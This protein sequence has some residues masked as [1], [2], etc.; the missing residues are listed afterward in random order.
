MKGKILGLGICML[1]ITAIL[2]ISGK[3]VTTEK[4]DYL[5]HS[6][7]GGWYKTYGGPGLDCFKGLDVTHDDCY[8]LAGETEIDGDKQAWIVKIH[9]DGEL[10][11]EVTYGTTA[12]RDALWPVIATSDGGYLAGGW[13]YNASQETNDA[14]LIKTDGNGTILWVNTYGGDGDDQIYGLLEADDGYFAVGMTSSYSSTGNYDALVLKTDFDGNQLWLKTLPIENYYTEV[15]G[16]A[17]ANGDDG[18]IIVGGTSSASEASQARMIKIDEDGNILW[19]RTYGGVFTDW[20]LSVDN[21]HDN[22]YIVSGG[23]KCGPYGKGFWGPNIWLIK[24]D[25]E[26][27][28]VWDTSFGLPILKDYSLCVK[29]TSDGGYI[30]TGHMYGIGGVGLVADATH[31][32][33]SKICLIK[34]DSEGEPQWQKLMPETGHGRTVREID[35]GFIIAGFEGPGHG[36]GSE[37]GILIKT[38]SN[39]EI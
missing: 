34:T 31:A 27:T 36:T 35:D 10:L 33:W 8:I 18:Y 12:G 26:G 21:T 17:K 23:T 13:F 25:N 24:V 9:T 29:S 19:D 6:L 15:N 32:P 3:M 16:I 2:P 5:A 20:W 38:D 28:I 37:H 1:L 4:N 14:L 30:V 7:N 39:G 11:W 22:N